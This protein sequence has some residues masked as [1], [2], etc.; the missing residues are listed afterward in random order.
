M[1]MA[2]RIHSGY[3]KGNV[4]CRKGRR[5]TGHAVLVVP[6]PGVTIFLF[7]GTHFTASVLSLLSCSM[8]VTHKWLCG[9]LFI[10]NRSWMIVI[11]SC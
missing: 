1:V 9:S 7:I 8:K 2:E 3:G 6:L 4:G 5:T 11:W 10:I